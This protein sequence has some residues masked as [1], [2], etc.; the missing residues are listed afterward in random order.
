MS[1]CQTVG[2]I[3]YLTLY[4]LHKLFKSNRD[5]IRPNNKSANGVKEA[6]MNSACL[7]TA[8]FAFTC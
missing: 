2:A 1:Q 4:Q 7:P 6:N 5:G 3:G 8:A